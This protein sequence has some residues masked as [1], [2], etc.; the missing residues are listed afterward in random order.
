MTKASAQT[1]PMMAACSPRKHTLWLPHRARSDHRM[2]R[3]GFD[4]PTASEGDMVML[5]KRPAFG[6]RVH[7]NDSRAIGGAT[8]GTPRTGREHMIGWRHM[9]RSRIASL[10]AI[11]AIGAFSLPLLASTTAAVAASPRTSPQPLT[12]QTSPDRK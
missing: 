1:V 3:R 2:Y 10:F 12:S 6:S 7:V 4:E 11:L 5:K 8:R 9:R